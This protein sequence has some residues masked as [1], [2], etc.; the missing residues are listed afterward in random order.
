MEKRPSKQ[1]KLNYPKTEYKLL[2]NSHVFLDD[3]EEE[4]MK[5]KSSIDLQFFTFEADSV[6]NRVA[7]CLFNAKLRG[8]KIRFIM[9]HFIDLFHNDYFIYR[10]RLNRGLQRI[11][12]GE[13]KDTKKLL[14][15]MAEAG[16][17]VRRS[18]PLG[19]LKLRRAFQRNHKK[20]VIIDSDLPKDAIAY[21]GGTNLS[22]HNVSWNDFMVKMK[23]SMIPILEN[24]FNATWE[25]K[26]INGKIKYE[27]GFVLTDSPDGDHEIIPFVIDLINN[28]KKSVV[29]E[30]PYLRGKN[31]W[32]SLIEASRRKVDVRII[33]PLNNNHKRFSAPTGRSLKNL[34]KN[35]VKVYRFKENKGMTHAKAVLV[36]NVA[37]FGS[38]N[39]SE[40]M[41]KR[42]C[43][44]NI[45]TH[46]RSMAKQMEKKL[47]EDM[48]MST[49]QEV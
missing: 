25:E 8:V 18:N 24:D 19:F 11:I 29:I 2:S 43:E 23:G 32:K 7:K 33:I 37:M 5:A 40:F 6:G 17:E 47:Y 49:L 44:V 12:S 22:E 34:I 13:W 36:D 48:A 42:L 14:K 10:P 39:L 46:N 41:A 16:I 31:I 27:D 1:K 38:S 21:V 26:N 4:I 9:D 45:A 30:S 35:G 15:K 28:S 20:I 3:L